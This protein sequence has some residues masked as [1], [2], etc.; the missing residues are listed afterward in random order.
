MKCIL[1]CCHSSSLH[2][3][4]QMLKKKLLVGIVVPSKA[5][6]FHQHIS[7]LAKL[8]N[9]DLLITSAD[10]LNDKLL[11]W[12]EERSPDVCIVNTFSYLLPKMVIDVPKYG[13]WN[14]HGGKLPEYRGPFPLFWQIKQ[15]VDELT[16]TLHKMNEFYDAG[17]IFQE[18]R[19]K[20][21]KWDTHD[22][23]L[24]RLAQN[25]SKMLGDLLEAL[26]TG[27][28]KLSPQDESKSKFY[29]K[30][31]MEDIIIQWNTMSASQILNL[32]RAC[33][34]SA[35]GAVAYFRSAEVRVYEVEAV[36]LTDPPEAAP[37]TVAAVGG[38]PN[39][40]I[41]CIDSSILR[42]NVL[43]VEG[44]ISSGMNFKKIMDVATG[45]KFLSSQEL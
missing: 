15:G 2:L 11:T 19:L 26:P 20:I 6:E 34:L 1:F 29:K 25:A 21:G 43:A 22:V 44:V 5:V 40:Y 28:L 38:D 45:E 30:P 4:Q 31:M 8:S 7:F 37:G 9:V 33:N 42:V 24:N 36:P 3:A 23:A 27:D 13:T 32:V 41:L 35:G 39:L 18:T 17:S 12:L 16:L 10:E 14:F